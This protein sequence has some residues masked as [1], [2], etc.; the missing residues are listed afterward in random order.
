MTIS[1]LAKVANMDCQFNF[2]QI[3]QTPIKRHVKIRS[4]VTAYNPE[5]ADYLKS[6]KQPDKYR[7]AWSSPISPLF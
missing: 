7:N 4:S 2:V 6:R 1:R 3:A 5:F